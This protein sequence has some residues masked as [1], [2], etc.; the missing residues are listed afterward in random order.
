MAGYRACLVCYVYSE[1]TQMDARVQS[2]VHKTYLLHCVQ[3]P[4]EL[5]F[6]ILASRVAGRHTGQVHGHSKPQHPANRGHL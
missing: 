6:G 3:L 1:C 5:Q 4:T 2:L